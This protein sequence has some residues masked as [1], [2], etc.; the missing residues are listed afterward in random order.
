MTPLRPR[1]GDMVIYRSPVDNGKGNDVLS[2]AVVLRTRATTVA[3][4]ISRWTPEQRKVVSLTDCSVV[5]ET[6]GRPEGVVDEL[7]DDHTVDLL[8]HG[9]GHDYRAYSV[10][11][12]RGRGQWMW[13][14]EVRQ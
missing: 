1:L 6:V 3:T 9:L 14:E 13:P 11:R 12:G 10:S 8:V 7:P 5:H 4:V 2:P